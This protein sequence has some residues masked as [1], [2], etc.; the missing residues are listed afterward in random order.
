MKA[1]LVKENSG[2][3]KSAKSYR[4]ISGES[5]SEKRAAK[6]IGGGVIFGG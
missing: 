2:S 1:A 6:I 4:N 5:S 3:E